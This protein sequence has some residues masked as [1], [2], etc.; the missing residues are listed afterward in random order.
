MKKVVVSYANINNNEG[1][2][3]I[4]MIVQ[5]GVD[6]EFADEYRVTG[7]LLKTNSIETIKTADGYTITSA[8]IAL[9]AQDIA[10]WLKNTN[11]ADVNEAFEN[12]GNTEYEQ[13]SAKFSN[14]SYWKQ[15]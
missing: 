7:V 5:K 10:S 6:I 3:L 14:E 2:E 12:C 15:V 9:M 4:D 8:D 1:Y 11:Y 13:L